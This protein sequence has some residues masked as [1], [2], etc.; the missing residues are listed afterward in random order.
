MLALEGRVTARHMVQLLDADRGAISRPF[1]P[2]PQHGLLRFEGDPADRRLRYAF[3]TPAGRALHDRIFR[4]ACLR[5]QVAPSALSDE[6]GYTL[7]DLLRRVY[8]N[9]PAVEGAS[10]EFIRQ[11]REALG[12]CPDAP[13]LRRREGQGLR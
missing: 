3:F 10:Q 13:A 2:M 6:E 7:R 4:F 12:I 8:V 11:E 9:P 5:E 1:K